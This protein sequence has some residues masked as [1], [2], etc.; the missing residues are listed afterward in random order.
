MNFVKI[1]FL[2]FALFSKV[3]ESLPKNILLGRYFRD[4]PRARQVMRDRNM[5]VKLLAGKS[6]RSPRLSLRGQVTSLP[7][8]NP[9]LF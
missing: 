7:N 1:H 4:H 2:T 9:L 8:P 5:A 6:S 3:C